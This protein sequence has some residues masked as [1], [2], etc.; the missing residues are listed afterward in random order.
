MIVQFQPILRRRSG[1]LGLR[2]LLAIAAGVALFFAVG[3]VGFYLR[4]HG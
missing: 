2:L 3:V 1:R 4:G